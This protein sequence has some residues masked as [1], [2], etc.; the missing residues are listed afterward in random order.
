MSDSGIRYAL[1]S[2]G[3]RQSVTDCLGF[4]F[5]AARSFTEVRIG[6][7]Q[8]FR[9]QLVD[10]SPRCQGRYASRARR[11]EWFVGLGL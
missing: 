4:D 11:W 9:G 1:L 7:P 8:N 5:S 2:W 6:W 3:D 10:E